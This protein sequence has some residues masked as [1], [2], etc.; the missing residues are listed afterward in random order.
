M[1]TFDLFRSKHL[2][3]NITH[4]SKPFSKPVQVL[5]T[6]SFITGLFLI[7][8]FLSLKNYKGVGEL[9]EM[10]AILFLFYFA[11]IF[12]GIMRLK[13]ETNQKVD[14]FKGFKFG[15]LITLLSTFL[16]TMFILFYLKADHTALLHLKEQ[17]AFGRTVTPVTVSAGMFFEGIA[18][19]VI[20]TFG[21]MQ[22]FKEY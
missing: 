20:V 7:L 15:M 12:I 5:L 2:V 6:Q 19:G 8:C 13:N 1:A 10:T 21:V 17:L 14:Y 18:C 11:A 4:S 22:Y 9:S 3:R 16:F